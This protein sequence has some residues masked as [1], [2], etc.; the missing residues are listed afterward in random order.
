MQMVLG[1]RSEREGITTIPTPAHTRQVAGPALLCSCPPVWFTC[2]PST[3]AT[4]AAQM[5]LHRPIPC[6]PA[7]KDGASSL[8]LMTSVPIPLTATVVGAGE[9]ITH[10]TQATSWQSHSRTSSPELSP[11]VLARPTV[12]SRVLHLVRGRSGSLWFMTLWAVVPTAGVGEGWIMGT[13]PLLLCHL[14]ADEW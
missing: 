14:T 11:W 7:S 5:K 13:S 12:L 1:G 10:H 8:A 6:M 3:R 2:G 9:V 4:R